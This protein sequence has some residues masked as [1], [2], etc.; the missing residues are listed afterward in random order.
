MPIFFSRDGL[1]LSV[2]PVAADQPRYLGPAP[3]G[4]LPQVAPQQTARRAALF[5]VLLLAQ[6]LLHPAV[7]LL[8]IF[9]FEPDCF[10]GF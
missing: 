2:G 6:K 5:L 3:A 4:H 7:N 8:T 1:E 9:T 10:A